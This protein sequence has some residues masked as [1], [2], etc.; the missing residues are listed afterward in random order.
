MSSIWINGAFYSKDPVTGNR[1]PKDSF[2]NQVLDVVNSWESGQAVF[3]FST[4]GST[5][6]P[7]TIE[8][9]RRQIE[10]SAMATLNFL[11][12]KQGS[13]LLCLDPS[14][15]AGF[16]MIIRAIIGKL[17]LMAVTPSSNPLNELPIKNGLTLL[18]IVPLQLK[19]ILKNS[20]SKN[21]LKKIDHVLIGGA[22]LS[23]DLE[24]KLEIFPN[25]IYQTF[26]MTETAS[27]FALRRIS[28]SETYDSYQVLPGVRIEQDDRGCMTIEGDITGGKKI[29]TNDLID[30]VSPGL[31]KWIGRLD[32]VINSG[33]RKIVVE[34]LENVIRSNLNSKD[35]HT[36]FFIYGSPDPLLGE[37]IVMILQCHEENHVKEIRNVL[38]PKLQKYDM[39]REWRIIDSFILTDTGKLDRKESHRKSKPIVFA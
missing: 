1:Q 38:E 31:F 3:S 7:K 30:C 11:N 22:A 15:I 8:L 34:M 26:G 6:I 20:V 5:G 13:A 32:H 21:L 36:P 28:G 12:I 18:A 33:G 19:T 14:Y 29:I 2:A 9:T 10:A 35:I 37:R 25:A 16:M 24:K 39:P 17:N 4:S 23:D 27:H